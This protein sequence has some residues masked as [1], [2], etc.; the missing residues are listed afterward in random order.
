[1]KKSRRSDRETQSQL[2]VMIIDGHV[3]RLDPEVSPSQKT[4]LPVLV[5]ESPVAP[6]TRREPGGADA[7]WGLPHNPSLRWVLAI[8]LGIS[9]VLVVALM[10]LP[11]IN[12][13]NAARPNNLTAGLVLD[14]E[15]PANGSDSWNDLITRQPDSHQI[16]RTYA[17]ARIA[18]DLLPLL[19]HPDTLAP[20]IRAKFRPIL[21]PHDWTPPADSTWSVM[22]NHTCPYA[23][24]EGSLPDF[25]TFS[26]YFILS[27]NHLL[28]DWKATTGYGTATFDELQQQQGDP[29]EIRAW[30]FPSNFYTGQFPEANFQS[31]QLTAPDYRKT[32]WTYTQRGDA[33]D[34]ALT[35]L[36][37]SGPIPE[38]P[39]TPEKVTLRLQ[40][41]TPG[42]L[43][44][45]WRIQ[46]MLHKD[47]ITL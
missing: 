14:R 39:T 43:P 34:T 30:I 18:D 1:L 38:N 23:I 26:A 37:P 20:L 19:R 21:V 29:S 25:S 40:S 36:F 42:A 45:Q 41:A 4:S 5:P 2:K 8:S 16:F 33:A 7:N 31:Y 44:N 27:H 35:Q 11:L 46:E 12:Q 13:P 24:L 6:D 22:D 17:R 47:W 32:L 9:A 15:T 3:L 28:L 10:L